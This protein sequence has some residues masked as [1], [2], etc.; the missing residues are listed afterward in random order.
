M[1]TAGYFYH[2]VASVYGG[3]AQRWLV[4]RSEPRRHAEVQAL[5]KH[6]ARERDQ[7]DQALKKL[8]RQVFNGEANAQQALQRFDAQWKLHRVGGE[9]MAHE[10]YAAAG[11]PT[12]ASATVTKWTLAARVS[13]DEA[14]I[15]QKHQ[16]LGNYIIATNELDPDTLSAE[17]LLTIYKDQN[18]SVERGFR[19]LKDP[20][21]FADSLFLKKPARIM[22]LL[23][24][25][26][27]ESAGLCAG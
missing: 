3:V 11:R 18:S 6:I 20:M 10:R 24:V 7:L 22:A 8:A 21:F 17:A 19:F 27:L 14:I 12:P 15:A 16:P 4:V 26:E 9:V 1:L 23:M 5:E 25:M 13:R 2:E